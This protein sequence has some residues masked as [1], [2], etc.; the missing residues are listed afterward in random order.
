LHTFHIFAIRTKDRSSLASY[1]KGEGIQTSVRY[2]VPMHLQ[3]A[4]EYLQYHEGDFPQAEA[5][6]RENLSLPMY[7]ELTQE[8]VEY[9][10]DKIE[11]WVRTR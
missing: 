2:P 1:L 6:A 4:L 11:G 3:P 7:P 10:C 8:Q 9:V 5:W